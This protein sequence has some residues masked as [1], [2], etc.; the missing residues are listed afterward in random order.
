L[1]LVH[2]LLGGRFGERQSVGAVTA[3][4]A[5]HCDWRLPTIAEL[6][7]IVDTSV[8]GCGDISL[9][10]PCID[11]TFGPTAASDGY[12]SSTTEDG[13]ADNAWAVRFGFGD[14]ASPSKA[15]A[16]FVR[17]VRGGS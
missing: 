3:V 10:T 11:P 15:L 4:F 5:G 6:Q 16:I 14:L 12:W 9:T 8:A 2:I 17:A 13:V 1:L 7:T